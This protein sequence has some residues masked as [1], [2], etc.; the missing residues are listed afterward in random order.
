MR[1]LA[2]VRRDR[3]V[4]TQKRHWIFVVMNGSHP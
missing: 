1:A 2:R 3:Q 4:A